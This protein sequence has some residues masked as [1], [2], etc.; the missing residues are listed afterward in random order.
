MNKYINAI[1]LS[2][3]VGQAYAIV[4]MEKKIPGKMEDLSLSVPDGESFSN[5][6]SVWLQKAGEKCDFKEFKII[7]YAERNESYGDAPSLNLANGKYEAE[8]FPA[9]VSGVFQC[10]TGS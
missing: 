5:V 10:L 3:L 2:S 1:I 8:K 6:R 4:P 7:R 9:S